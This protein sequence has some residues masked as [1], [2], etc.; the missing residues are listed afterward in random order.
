[1]KKTLVTGIAGQDGSYLA[2]HLYAD[3]HLKGAPLAPELSGSLLDL[4]ERG[5]RAYHG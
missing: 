3:P 2:V 5:G 4:A 1:M